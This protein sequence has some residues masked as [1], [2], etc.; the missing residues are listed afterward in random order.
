MSGRTMTPGGLIK[1]TVQV[2]EGQLTELD[3][4][5][6]DFGSRSDLV[7]RYVDLGLERDRRADASAIEPV[8]AAI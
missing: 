4:R 6:G 7:R 1:I 5:T 2:T 8:E 3:E